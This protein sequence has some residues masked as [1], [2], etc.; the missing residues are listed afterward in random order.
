MF[1]LTRRNR[2]RDQ[3]AEMIR[4]YKDFDGQEALTGSAA[5]VA[6]V[7]EIQATQ[8]LAAHQVTGRSLNWSSFAVAEVIAGLCGWAAWA[9][10]PAEIWYFTVLIILAVLM[11]SLLAVAGVGVL[12]QTPDENA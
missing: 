9:M 8:L 6:E 5:K 2:I 12:V 3:L 7:V 11:G 1:G 10:W 4:L